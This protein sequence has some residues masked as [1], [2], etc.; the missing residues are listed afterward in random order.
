MP[1]VRRQRI[2]PLDG[3]SALLRYAATNRLNSHR[4]RMLHRDAPIINRRGPPLVPLAR[5]LERVKIGTE[6][7]IGPCTAY[8]EGLANQTQA[9]ARDGI[10]QAVRRPAVELPRPGIARPV[11]YPAAPADRRIATTITGRVA[12]GHLFAGPSVK[13]LSVS[14]YATL[15]GVSTSH[16]QRPMQYASSGGCRKEVSLSELRFSQGRRWRVRSNARCVVR[17][18]S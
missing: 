5:P 17:P 8:S 16:S 11:P 7:S 10:R 9:P 1:C 14:G 6:Q 4:S 3:L 2:A 12:R 15:T 18:G 13:R